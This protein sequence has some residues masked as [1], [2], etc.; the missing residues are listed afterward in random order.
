MQKDRIG[1]VGHIRF[2]LYPRHYFRWYFKPSQETDVGILTTYASNTRIRLTAFN[3]IDEPVEATMTMEDVLPG[4]WLMRQGISDTFDQMDAQSE[5]VR[6]VNRFSGFK[7]I[8]APGKYTTMEMELSVPAQSAYWNR[9]DLAITREDVLIREDCVR[10]RVHNIGAVESSMTT[11]VLRAPDGQVL[12]RSNIPPI[13]APIDLYPKVMEIPLWT[14]GIAL[15]GCTIEL[16][17][18]HLL[19]E[20]TKENNVVQL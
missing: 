7:V 1:G 4:Q 5:E 6:E 19:D 14:R 11:M 10:V 2:A 17:P 9:T 8:F 20:I 12:R 16:D 18:E 15:Q 13:E 3:M